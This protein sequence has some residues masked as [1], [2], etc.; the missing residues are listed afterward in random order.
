MIFNTST[1]CLEIN[2]GTSSSAWQ[3]VKCTTCGANVA[4]GVWK[5]FLCYNLGA[6]PNVDP[7]SPSWE[8]N[9]DYYQ[10]GTITFAAAGPTNGST[11]NAAAPAGWNS[12]GGGSDGSWADAP[13]AKGTQDP[14][15]AGFR[16]PSYTQWAGVE[17]NNTKTDVGSWLGGNNN[18]NSGKFLGSG[19]FLPATGIRDWF[20]G[21]LFNRG[22]NGYYWSS[23][24]VDSEDAWPLGFLNGGVF[25]FPSTRAYG[26]S[27]RC[28]AE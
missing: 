20:N 18:Y 23:T 27:L 1:R 24:V 16:V 4:P 8:L 15:P 2:L 9:G 11:P 6:N 28:I 22:V 10:W 7:F 13:N 12:S 21:M 14:C 17:A 19:L 26:F 25:I 5:E 3:T